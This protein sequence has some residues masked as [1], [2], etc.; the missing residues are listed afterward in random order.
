MFLD[1]SFNSLTTVL[2]NVH[3]AFIETAMKMCAYISCLPTSKQ[4]GAKLVVKTFQDLVAL[5]F[6]LMKSKGKTKKNVGYECALNRAQVE[7]LAVTAFLEVLG[8][9]QS[10]YREVL[11]WLTTRL[12]ELKRTRKGTGKRNG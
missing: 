6:V 5:A 3:S 7:G 9:K 12:E 1:T 10:R 2:S 4:P 11:T 8:R